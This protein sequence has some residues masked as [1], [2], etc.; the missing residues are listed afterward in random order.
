VVRPVSLVRLIR[1]LKSWAVPE[2]HSRLPASLE[3][4]ATGASHESPSVADS[5]SAR[6]AGRSEYSAYGARRAYEWCP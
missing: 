4:G 6:N 1:A 3:G 5:T 2:A